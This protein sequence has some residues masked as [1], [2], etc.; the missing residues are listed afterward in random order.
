[1]ASNGNQFRY[2]E[3]SEMA[4]S[5]IEWIYDY[6]LKEFGFIQA[7]EYLN[8]IHQLFEQLTLFPNEGI[9]R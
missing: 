9:S 3:L 7:E 2:Y 4:D 8:G 1:M 5:D 6:S